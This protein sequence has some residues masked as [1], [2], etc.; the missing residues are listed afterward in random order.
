ME[1]LAIPQHISKV[2]LYT[3]QS[4]LLCF[5][6]SVYYK[7]QIVCSLSLLATYF[8]TMLHWY[9]L[10]DTGIIKKLD[11]VAIIN[12]LVRF[13]YNGITMFCPTCQKIWMLTIIT[14]IIVYG[15]NINIFY[16]QTNSNIGYIMKPGYYSY[17][18]LEYT[19]PNTRERELS[20]YFTSY[21]HCVFLHV[22]ISTVSIYC[23]VIMP[24]N[25]PQNNETNDYVPQIAC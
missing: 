9:K 20:Y 21:I 14:I 25:P 8:T 12:L 13:Y 24:Y 11:I 22:I 4:I 7:F 1:Q 16:Y 18:S 23:A 10:Y 15:I 17:F 6:A 19:L 2:G 5:V 3:G